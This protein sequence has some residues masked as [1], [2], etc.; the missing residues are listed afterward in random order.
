[1]KVIVDIETDKINDH[2]N[3]KQG[4]INKIHCIVAKVL[5]K[6]EWLYYA[7]YPVEIRKA[8]YWDS[9]VQL[10]DILQASDCLILHNGIRFDIPAIQKF[11]PTWKPKKIEDTFILSSLFEPDRPGGH[12]LEQWGKD[13]KLY[14]QEH[15]DWTTFSPEMLA[16]CFRDVELTEK[17]YI[18]LDK[19]RQ[20]WLKNPMSNGLGWE[21]AIKLEYTIARLCMEM[22]E[23]G[24]KLD[25]LK[26]QKL[27]VTIQTELD[28]VDRQLMEVLPKRCIIDKVGVKKPF[29]KDGS[30]SKAVTDYFSEAERL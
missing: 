19:E 21:P 20:S 18:Y 5:G 9:L 4:K 14:K 24:V 15:E 12:S 8:Q 17:V 30:L 7:P 22:E 6:D 26:A 29:K 28:E 13:L 3:F 1:M 10:I 16:R 23:T 25:I 27:L 2:K 11:F